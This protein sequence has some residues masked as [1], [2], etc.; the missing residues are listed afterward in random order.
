MKKNILFLVLA[1]WGISFHIAVAA[2]LIFSDVSMKSW[3]SDAVKSLTDK[4]ILHGYSDHTFQPDRPVSRAELAVALDRMTA[5]LE[6]NPSPITFDGCGKL[7]NY[8]NQSWFA[9]ANLKYQQ[10]FLKPQ[11]LT[12]NMGDEYGEGC[13]SK[14]QNLFVFI[15][16]FFELG[17]G[18]LFTYDIKNDLLATPDKI[19][20]L[21]TY[22]ASEL[23][24]RI[25]NFINFKGFEGDG[26]TCR[27]YNG[28]YYF[29]ENR[30]EVT[31]KSC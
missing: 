10:E 20:T 13:L 26:G 29:I 18:K 27:E 30:V 4:G 21:P 19:N 11:K 2:S 14:D 17:C 1:L 15:P 5:Y 9:K 7:A 25:D 22:C 8:A 31:K 12:G 28:K 16:E 6:K 24:K 23:G 3:Y